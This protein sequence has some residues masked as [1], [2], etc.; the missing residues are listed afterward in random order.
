MSSAGEILGP[1]SRV[2]QLKDPKWECAPSPAFVGIWK[3]RHQLERWDV[4][5]HDEYSFPALLI[6]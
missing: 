6:V 1:D 4:S 5:G 2:S 3:P